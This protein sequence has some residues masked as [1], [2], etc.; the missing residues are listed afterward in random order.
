MK[1]DELIEEYV[2]LFIE[3]GK[4]FEDAN[5]KINNKLDTK[6]EKIFGKIS[7]RNQLK[8][9]SMYLNH[10]NDYV[11]FAVASNV[12][13]LEPELSK[14]ALKKVAD[15]DSLLKMVAEITLNENNN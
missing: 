14:E 1:N 15:G 3:Q 5:D 2:S 6:A 7:K 11:K 4:A 13:S 9:L 12:Y 8:K 10:E